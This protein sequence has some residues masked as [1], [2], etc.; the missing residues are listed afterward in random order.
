MHTFTDTAGRIWTLSLTLGSAIRVKDTLGIDLLQPEVGDSDSGGPLLTRLGTDE[1]LLGEVICCLLAPQIEAHQITEQQVRD[2][3]DGGTLL[4]AQRAFYAE[5]VDF[6]QGRGRGDRAKAV[7]A[8][9]SLIETAVKAIET[10]IEAIDPREMVHQA[11]EGS[12]AEAALIRGRTSGSS[13]AS[14]G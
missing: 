7:A 2:S 12:S 11:I 4:A 14:S 1:M 10:R 5:L 9:A 3:F 13:P 6:F 8:Q